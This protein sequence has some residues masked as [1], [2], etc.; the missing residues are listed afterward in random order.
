MSFLLITFFG[1]TVNYEM[2]FN[3]TCFEQCKDLMLNNTKTLKEGVFLAI[4]KFQVNPYD[5]ISFTIANTANPFPGF[6]GSI[7]IENTT[8]YY[9]KNTS[10]FNGSGNVVFRENVNYATV[11]DQT[12]Q[13]IVPDFSF[14]NET[15]S[16]CK[17]LGK[18]FV[19]YVKISYLYY[20]AQRYIMSNRVNFA[21]YFSCFCF[22][23]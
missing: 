19:F 17:H 16:D 18:D 6:S 9:D 2:I 21:C 12:I 14:K 4:R 10:F 22:M 8:Y 1:N 11:L 3:I 5:I 23:Y 13:F 7:T 15:K 20:N